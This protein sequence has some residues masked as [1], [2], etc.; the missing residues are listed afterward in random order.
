MMSLGMW[1]E[2]SELCDP[3]L[4]VATGANPGTEVRHAGLPGLLRALHSPLPHLFT[5]GWFQMS[6]DSNRAS[7]FGHALEC[8]LRLDFISWQL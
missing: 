1:L 5:R 3:S 7:H 6:P 8:F 4:C 2:S